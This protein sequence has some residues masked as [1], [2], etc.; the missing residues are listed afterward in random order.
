MSWKSNKDLILAG[1]RTDHIHVMYAPASNTAPSNLSG[2]GTWQTV[3]F[4]TL[5]EDGGGIASLAANALTIP[6]GRYL[7]EAKLYRNATTNQRE[8]FQSRIYDGSAVVKKQGIPSYIEG[9]YYYSNADAAVD[10]LMAYNGEFTLT[11]TKSIE[12]QI[13]L[14]SASVTLG[15]VRNVSG[16]NE[17]YQ[18]LKLWRV[19]Q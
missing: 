17:A 7:W 18:E 12:F 5:V 1:G 10:S 13:L 14:I 19:R 16:E 8:N 3:P 11:E 4:D 2:A 15:S 6:L 9:T